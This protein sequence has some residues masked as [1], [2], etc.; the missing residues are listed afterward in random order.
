MNLN[1]EMLLVIKCKSLEKLNS[2]KGLFK[3][4]MHVKLEHKFPSAQQ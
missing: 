1:D 3:F 2:I 4:L